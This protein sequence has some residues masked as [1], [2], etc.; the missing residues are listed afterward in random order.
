[1]FLVSLFNLVLLGSEDNIMKYAGYIAFLSKGE[2]IIH[3][4]VKCTYSQERNMNLRVVI[5]EEQKCVLL[6]SRLL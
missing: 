2:K 5:T 6:K 1:M 4:F 3:V